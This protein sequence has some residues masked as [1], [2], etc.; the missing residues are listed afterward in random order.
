M[1]FKDQSEIILTLINKVDNFWNLFFIS[2]LAIITWFL[3][4]GNNL[5]LLHTIIATVIYS[6][7]TYHNTISQLRAYSFLNLNINEMKLNMESYNLKSHDL[8]DNLNKLSY[9]Y[10]TLLVT[11]VYGLML[12]L[13]LGLF[14]TQH[15][16]LI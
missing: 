1:T 6:F 12:S 2:N 13:V 10:R 14:W 3:T 11:I 7:Y 5:S 4:K 15:Y 16:N 8:I 9:R